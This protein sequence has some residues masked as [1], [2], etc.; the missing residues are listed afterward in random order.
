MNHQHFL[1]R[2]SFWSLFT[3]TCVTLGALGA[4]TLRP[5]QAANFVVNEQGDTVD[6]NPGDGI[7]DDGTGPGTNCTLR[8]AIMEANALAGTDT[9]SYTHLTLPTIHLV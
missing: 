6:A 4:F 8:A 9:V 3:I 7:C 5:V 2:K 1:G